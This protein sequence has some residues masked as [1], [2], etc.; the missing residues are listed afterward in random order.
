VDGVLAAE[1]AVFVHFKTLGCVLLVFY[2]VVIA[3]LAF[4]ASQSNFNSHLN[5]TS[6]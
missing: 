4:V 2:G 6:L 3:L 1:A 5:G